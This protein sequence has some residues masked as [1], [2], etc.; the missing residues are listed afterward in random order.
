VDEAEAPYNLQFSNRSDNIVQNNM[1][2]WCRMN[3]KVCGRKK[4]CPIRG[5]TLLEED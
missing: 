3:W 1:M 5:I 4:S 2:D